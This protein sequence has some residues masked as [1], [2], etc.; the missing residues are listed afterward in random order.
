M[1]SGEHRVGPWL[2][3]VRTGRGPSGPDGDGDGDGPD[4]DG[5][6][7]TGTDGPDGDWGRTGR[8]LFRDGRTGRGLFRVPGEVRS[9]S[10]KSEARRRGCRNSSQVPG[11]V[12]AGRRYATM[13]HPELLR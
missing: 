2:D 3:T 4:G 5:T 10:E 1:G 7:R 6:D 11:R 13:G 8:G 9:G 12:A